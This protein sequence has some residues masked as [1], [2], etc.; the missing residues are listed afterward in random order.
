VIGLDGGVE[1]AEVLASTNPL[2]D[3][4]A[5]D[6]VRKWRYR[7]ATMNGAP[8]RVYFTVVVDFVVR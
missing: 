3:R 7:A 4:A 6:A 5:A 8:V 2:F 1:S